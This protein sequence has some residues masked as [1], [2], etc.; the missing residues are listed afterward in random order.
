MAVYFYDTGDHPAGFVGFRVATTLGQAN[1]FRQKY[2]SLEEYGHSTGSRLAHELDAMWRAE[3]AGVLRTNKLRS[4]HGNA[5]PGALVVGLNA[6]FRVNRP[7]KENQQGLI[8]PVFAVCIPG[9]GKGQKLFSIRK[10]G[11]DAAFTEA[12]DYYCHIHALTNEEI[13]ILLKLK[14]KPELFIHTLRLNLLKRGI[15]I[16]AAEVAQL[17]KK[18][19]RK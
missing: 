11:L 8:T 5:G 12:V 2:F 10:L 14:P 3:A 7:R 18:A 19:G 13:N 16:T 4:K 9:Y 17:M 15:I 1:D 6:K